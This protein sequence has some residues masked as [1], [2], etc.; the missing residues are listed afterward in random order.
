MLHVPVY[1]LSFT[2]ADLV[3]GAPWLKTL[4]PHIA[5]YDALSIKFYNHNSF[6]TI[7]G[8]KLPSLNQAQFHHILCL[9]NTHSIDS[10]F[11]LQLHHVDHHSDPKHSLP[12]DL[13]PDL[14]SLLTTFL[15]V[16]SEPVGLPPVRAQDHAIPLL[17]GSNPVKVRPYRYPHC[18]KEQIELMVKDMLEQGLIQPSSSPFS[19]PVLL[20]KKKDGTWRFCIDYRTLNAI[21][22]KDSFPIP[23]VDE[24]LDELFGATYFSKLDLR[25]GY[26]QILVK[27][28]DRC[29]TAFHTHQGLYE[30][31]VM[32]FG[33]SNAPAS[34]QSLMNNVFKNQ[35]RKSVLVFFDDILVYSPSWA[36][37]LEHLVVVLS[38]LR[39]HTLFAKLTKCCF[40][41]T[42]VD[43]LG[44]TISSQGVEMDNSKIQA[45]LDWPVP[46]NI[47]Q[48]HGFLGLS[49]YYRRFI[50]GYA[51]IAAP[52]T[53]LLKKDAFLWHHQAT[54]A[55]QNLKEAITRAPVLALPD[56][57]QQF[58]LETDAS[59]SGIGA[60]LS[61]SKHPIAYFSMK[62][63]PRM[64]KQ[65]AY[66]RELYAITEALAKFRHYLIGHKFTIKTVQQ[67][68]KALTDQTI[69]TPE[70]Q[71]WLHKFLGYDFTIE[72]KPGCENIAADALSHSFFM[73]LSAPHA[74]VITLIHEAVNQDPHL[75]AIRNQ[76]ILGECSDPH[77]QVRN[78]M[79]FWKSRLVVPSDK[80]IIDSLLQEFHAS[81]LGGH[82]GIS[83][84][85]ARLATQFYWPTMNRD[86]RDFVTQCLIYQQA[87]AST[88]LPAGLLQPPPIPTQIW[89]DIA[90]DFITGLPN[91]HSYS[92]VF[93]VVDRLSKY[94]HFTALKSDYT[95]VKVA[96][97]F[98]NSIVKLHGFPKSIV[99]DRDKVFTSQFWQQL[100]K[101]SGTTLA[102]STVY[103]LQTDGQS[104]AVNKCLEMYLRCFTSQN[105]K[106]WSKLLPWAELW[107]NAAFHTSIGMC[108][109]KAVY[110]RDPPM[111]VKYD[112]SH[113]DPPSLQTLLQERD[114]VLHFLKANL[115]KAQQTMKKFADAKRRL[116]EFQVI[117][118]VGSVAYR[119]QLPLTAK[120]HPVFHVSALKLQRRAYNSL[121]AAAFDYNRVGTNS[122]AS[123]H[124][125]I[126]RHSA[127]TITGPTSSG[128]MGK[129]PNFSCH[130]G[131][132]I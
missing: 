102:M 130:L 86:I 58:A 18:Q 129:S 90:M 41:M 69:Q 105:P 98:M 47:K 89:E 24:L 120:I 55:F 12:R 96:E 83:R 25:S 57:Q 30:W 48:L 104:E 116:L 84:T 37:H 11:T 34:F 31:L 118:K 60:I 70:Q 91:S 68:L 52:L 124:Y 59:G 127:T 53:S 10:S 88:A 38:L 19:S 74:S 121:H 46:T 115:L 123:I 29:K 4:G 33:L 62:L 63:S 32:P 61:Q 28:E 80:P 50:K 103:H 73:A 6:I 43:Y 44:H 64:Q 114:A 7:Y 2:D 40:G 75:V 21:T 106:A 131:K 49:G 101:L 39:H 92:A 13:P 45:V 111:L 107:Y 65:S 26:H 56:F 128:S 23:T 66:V 16:F 35:L 109:F 77:Y 8:D 95:V 5:D 71:Q 87:K 125:S 54:V 113:L 42:K 67:S 9:Q 82:A 14:H 132:L 78:D 1:L 100:F 81:P 93:V 3:L 36:T 51:S 97:I 117:D 20:V 17:E 15:D 72:Y 122:D 22:I 27:T 112:I 119:L 85:K 108:P 126:S 79:L 94:N 110:G 76:C 99:S